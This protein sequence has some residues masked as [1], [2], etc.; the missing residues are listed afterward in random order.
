MLQ[1]FLTLPAGTGEGQP[2]VFL[3]RS[4]FA[5]LHRSCQG[6]QPPLPTARGGR[7]GAD[8]RV[9]CCRSSAPQGWPWGQRSQH[10]SS[11]AQQ[12]APLPGPAVTPH[13][14]QGQRFQL[15]H[16]WFPKRPL[17][18]PKAPG[19]RAL[20]LPPSRL[21]KMSLYCVTLAPSVLTHGNSHSE[22]S[23]T[24]LLLDMGFESSRIQ[25]LCPQ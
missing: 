8:V 22:E 15:L 14:S 12:P 13:T 24:Q 21:E 11:R 6:L 23:R 16:R 18:A 9:P 1:G 20:P 3:R 19:G 4:P 5:A 10:C 2:K 7:T 17:P 25:F